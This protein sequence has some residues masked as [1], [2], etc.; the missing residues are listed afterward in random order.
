MNIKLILTVAI[1]C[2]VASLGGCATMGSSKDSSALNSGISD[3]VDV[4]YIA[5]V[6]QEALR[7]FGTVVWVNPPQ[8]PEPQQPVQ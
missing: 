2:G 1:A 5:A 7:H 6:N 4:A 3:N 8:K